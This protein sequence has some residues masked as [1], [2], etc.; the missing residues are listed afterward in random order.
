MLEGTETLSQIPARKRNERRPVWRRRVSAAVLPESHVSIDQRCL[1]WR[2]LHSPEVFFAE[3]FVHRP[4]ANGGQKHS[5]RVYPCVALRGGPSS[6]KNRPRRAQRNQFMRV[7]RQI[8]RRQGPRIFHEISRHPMIFARPRDV[9]HQ[10]PKIP[11][12]ELRA[13]FP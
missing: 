2:K 12:M 10:L 7:Y 8:V 6:N 1:D 13:A 4:R 11:P 5:F 3:Q 9:L